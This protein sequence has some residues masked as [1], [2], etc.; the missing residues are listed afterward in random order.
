MLEM[1]LQHA[2]HS[3]QV[4]IAELD[5]SVRLLALLRPVGSNLKLSRHPERKR[6]NADVVKLSLKKSLVIRVPP[7][8]HAAILIK[9]EIAG[10]RPSVYISETSHRHKYLH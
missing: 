2:L 1:L 4:T 7:H 10:V 5:C 9:V 8:R 6:D 3:S